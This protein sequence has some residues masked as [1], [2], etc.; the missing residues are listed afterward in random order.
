MSPLY[1][2]FVEVLVCRYRP[3][4]GFASARRDPVRNLIDVVGRGFAEEASVV[5]N[6]V[7]RPS[8]GA[9]ALQVCVIDGVLM[10]EVPL[11]DV[12]EDLAHAVLADRREGRK[13]PEALHAYVHLFVPDVASFLDGL[14]VQLGRER[15]G[16]ALSCVSSD[17]VF[18]AEP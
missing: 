17:G 18:V 5:A 10:T 16:A 13:A 1:L 6:L 8:G 9:G 2:D 12:V 3:G 14:D 15:S 7:T 11:S 4:R